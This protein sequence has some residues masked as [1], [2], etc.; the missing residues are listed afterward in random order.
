MVKEKNKINVESNLNRLSRL[1]LSVTRATPPETIDFFFIQMPTTTV[2]T[3]TRDNWTK[4]PKRPK[5]AKRIN[6]TVI[7]EATGQ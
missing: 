2:C 6:E 1:D 3:K 7:R 4:R 5:R